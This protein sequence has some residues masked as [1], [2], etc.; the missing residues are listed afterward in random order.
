MTKEQREKISKGL[1]AKNLFGD[2][3]PFFGKKHSPETIEKIRKSS[4]GRKFSKE[5]NENL[6][7]IRAGKL[8][9][10]FGVR[11]PMYG[12]PLKKN[13]CQWFDVDG[14]RC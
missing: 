3:N 9:P 11:S 2:R 7:K 5:R 12:K 6:S 4:I 10:M 1:K 13:R 8:N 14:I